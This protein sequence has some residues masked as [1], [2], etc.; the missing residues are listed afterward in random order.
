VT[1][2]SGTPKKDLLIAWTRECFAAAGLQASA[3]EARDY[4]AI[5]AQ[6]IVED[7][8]AEFAR[9]SSVPHG[10]GS[11]TVAGG[12]PVPTFLTY[13]RSSA[14][15]DAGGRLDAFDEIY[16]RFVLET[17]QVEAAGPLGGGNAAY[18]RAV[19]AADEIFS[20]FFTERTEDTVRQLHDGFGD[21]TTPPID[22]SKVTI[23]RSGSLS[24]G[25]CAVMSIAAFGTLTGAM[26]AVSRMG[27]RR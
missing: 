10:T 27:F 1:P 6:T 26:I 13:L 19:N 17:E 5:A 3:K 4:A 2:A 24:G 18:N 7:G 20:Q 21:A 23:G 16:E 8:F 15:S 14:P 22:M 12:S 9:G 25:G 11:K